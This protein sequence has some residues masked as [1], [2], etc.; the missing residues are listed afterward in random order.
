LKGSQS[1]FNPSQCS[2][3]YTDGKEKNNGE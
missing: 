2:R 1:S 3:N